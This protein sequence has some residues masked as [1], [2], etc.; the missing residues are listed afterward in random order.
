MIIISYTYILLIFSA[1]HDA[2][3]GTA[4]LLTLELLHMIH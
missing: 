4:D 1:G 3:E 2:A